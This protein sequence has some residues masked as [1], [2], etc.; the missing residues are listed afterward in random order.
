MV[1]RP[2]ARTGE[3]RGTD[4]C[5]GATA[6]GT[7]H[8]MWKGSGGRARRR[9]WLLAALGPIMLAGSVAGTLAGGLPIQFD[10]DNVYPN[11]IVA[12]F[13]PLLGALVLSRL[14]RHPIGWLFLCCGL[15]SGLSMVVYDYAEYGL[16]LHPGSLPLALAAGW[17][18]SW[19]WT[20]GFAPLV[21]VAVLLFPDGSLPGPRWRWLLRLQI[22]TLAAMVLIN[23]FL[24][25]HL[26]NHP[27]RDNPLGVPLPV[28][29]F[30]IADVASHV[31]MIAGM[32]GSV[33]AAVVRWRRGRG[34]ERAPL[35]WFA[36]AI[37]GVVAA[38]LVP[39]PPLLGNV[40][41]AIA[42]PLLPISVVAAILR[43]HLSGI[44]VVV[45]RSLLYAALTVVL[46]MAYAVIVALLGAVLRDRW[47]TAAA[48]VATT[49]VAVAFAPVRVRLQRSVDRFVYGDRTDP[50]AILSGLGRRL[51]GR[52]DS[53]LLTE[54]VEAVTMSLR[55]PYARVEVDRGGRPLLSAETGRAVGTLHEV[56]LIFRGN[57][58]GRLLVAPR[59]ERDP[60]HAIDLRLLDD[61]GRQIGVAAYAVRLADDLRRSRE[62]I[63]ATRE[64]ERRRIRRDLHDGLGPAL[65]GVALGLDAVRR[66]AATAPTEAAT[67]ATTLKQEVQASLAEVR[68]LVEDLRPPALDELGL[69]GAVRRQAERIAERYPRL[70]VTV[71]ITDLPPLPAAVEVGAY[72]I[73]AEALTNVWRHA[74]A[75][76]CRVHISMGQGG[77]LIIEVDDDGVGIPAIRRSGVGLSAMRERAS[78]LGGACQATSLASGGTRVAATIP[79]GAT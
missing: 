2:G 36:L 48:L 12:A 49:L 8:S 11:L 79:V 23:M 59:T 57:R 68:R 22:A 71:D 45:R 14:A 52:E 62:T 24:P 41:A 1:I 70:R 54:A 5:A 42:L 63:V 61:L 74:C 34:P 33:S 10:L 47:D 7:I 15:A 65:A 58:V 60:F 56:P 19:I 69:A 30:A 31:A 67:L 9:V 20:L 43:G 76:Q 55:L 37:I 73:T 25:G 66:L 40:I 50:Y 46:L 28:T 3:Y 53:D 26:Q 38:M 51:E 35:D 16:V 27:V 72:R 18:S 77:C 75:S 32:I 13:L 17:V 64:E 21:T 4:D 39:G 78:E 6:R 44:E 29:W